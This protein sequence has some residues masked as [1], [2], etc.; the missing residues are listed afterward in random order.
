M[1]VDYDI[2]KR[3]AEFKAKVRHAGFDEMRAFAE[4]QRAQREVESAKYL[5]KKYK[6]V[7]PEDI[8]MTMM[9][10]AIKYERM[11]STALLR[12]PR[13]VQE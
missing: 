10:E 1:L 5:V 12:R 13:P 7:A 3:V 9:D 6:A 2:P 8:V 11:A 4:V